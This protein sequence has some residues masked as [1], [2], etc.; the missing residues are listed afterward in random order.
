[1]K[2]ILPRKPGRP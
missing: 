2:M 1:M